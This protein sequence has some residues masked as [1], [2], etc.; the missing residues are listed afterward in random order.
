M[1]TSYVASLLGRCA[2]SHKNVLNFNNVLK[3]RSQFFEALHAAHMFS[4]KEKDKIKKILY[5]VQ[6]FPRCSYSS[7]NYP[8]L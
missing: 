6:S 2:R 1:F 4:L 3:Y 7:S 5:I 8:C